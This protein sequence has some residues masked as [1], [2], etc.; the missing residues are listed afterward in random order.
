MLSRK[1]IPSRQVEWLLDH[2]II[3]VSIDYRL[4]PEASILDGPIND[5]SHALAWARKGLP[6]IKPKHANVKFDGDRVG[7]VGWS[8]GGM[9]ALSLGWTA[10]SRHVQPPQAVTVFYCPTDYEDQ[11]ECIPSVVSI[12]N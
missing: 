8:S 3:P 6:N 2:G 12:P 11:C 1:D 4:C 9:L 10:K 5:V 7:V